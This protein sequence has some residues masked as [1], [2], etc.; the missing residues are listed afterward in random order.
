MTEDS[1]H[2]I[3]P[4]IERTS[5]GVD[6]K[7]REE[8]S[9]ASSDRRSATRTRLNLEVDYNDQ[10]PGE[11]YDPFARLARNLGCNDQVSGNPDDPFKA[12]ECESPTPY[13]SPRQYSPRLMR[14]WFK[15]E[16][17]PNSPVYDPYRNVVDYSPES[18]D[19]PEHPIEFPEVPI[20]H[21][22]PTTFHFRGVARKN[23]NTTDA[24][25]STKPQFYVR[26]CHK[27][28]GTCNWVGFSPSSGSLSSGSLSSDTGT[29]T[30]ISSNPHPSS[31]VKPL[32]T[33]ERLQVTEFLKD[34]SFY[35]DYKSDKELRELHDLVKLVN[36]FGDTSTS[37]TLRN[38]YAERAI[39]NIH[40]D[41]LVLYRAPRLGRILHFLAIQCCE[42]TIDKTDLLCHFKELW[43]TID[44]EASKS[45]SLTDIV[46]AVN[47]VTPSNLTKAEKNKAKRLRKKANKKRDRILI[48]ELKEKGFD[49][50]GF[51][52]LSLEEKNSIEVAFRPSSED[53]NYAKLL[54]RQ[55]HNEA[56]YCDED[57]DDSPISLMSAGEDIPGDFHLFADTHPRRSKSHK[58]RFHLQFIPAPWNL[59]RQGRIFAVNNVSKSREYRSFQ[60][61]IDSGASKHVTGNALLA[62]N[63]NLRDTTV[64]SAANGDLMPASKEGD[65]H[66]LTLE[67]EPIVIQQVHFVPALGANTLL[68]VTQLVEKDNAIVHFC[69]TGSYILFKSSGIQVPLTR[70]ENQLF[71][72]IQIA[73][74]NGKKPI[75]QMNENLSP[76]KFAVGDDVKVVASYF[77][78]VGKP[79]L[80][81]YF[82]GYVKSLGPP[83][84]DGSNT[85]FIYF[86][87]DRK[88][89]KMREI[90]LEPST[91]QLTKETKV[92][93]KGK[94]VVSMN[95]SNNIRRSK[96][97][98]ENDKI[99]S[100][101][102]PSESK[103]T[104]SLQ[105]PPP[106]L[107]QPLPSSSSTPS[108]LSSSSSSF[109]TP[110]KTSQT[111]KPD[112]NLTHEISPDF[113]CRPDER[114]RNFKS[115]GF[116]LSDKF[117]LKHLALSHLNSAAMLKLYPDLKIPN[118]W[119][120][121][122]CLESNFQT[123]KHSSVQVIASSPHDVW[124]VDSF[125]PIH[126]PSNSGYVGATIIKDQYSKSGY[127]HFRKSAP[128]SSNTIEALEAVATQTG[129]FP[130]QLHS[131]MGTE[132]VSEEV[133]MF[134]KKRLIKHTT[135]VAF[136]HSGNGGVETLIK[137]L[138]CHAK[139]NLLHSN[140]PAVFWVYALQYSL[141]CYNISPSYLAGWRSPHEILTGRPPI[142]DTSHPNAIPLHPFGCVVYYKRHDHK[143][144]LAPN[145]TKGFYLGAS[146]DRGNSLIVG[147]LYHDGR[148]GFNVRHTIDVVVR[149]DENYFLEENRLKTPTQLGEKETI[150]IDE[151]TSEDALAIKE[152][153]ITPSNYI[154]YVDEMGDALVKSVEKFSSFIHYGYNDPIPFLGSVGTSSLP[155]P[156]SYKEALNR[157]EAEY[158]KEAIRKEWEENIL[159]KATTPVSI[160]SVA[161]KML[162]PTTL[163]LKTKPG[164]IYKARVCVLGNLQKIIRQRLDRAKKFS[165]EKTFSSSRSNSE[166]HGNTSST[167]SSS[168]TNIMKDSNDHGSLTN[169]MTFAPTV[170][171][172]SVRTLIALIGSKC[173][174]EDSVVRTGDV[175]AAFCIPKMPPDVE[176]YIQAPIKELRKE[177]VVW[178]LTSP[179]YGLEEAPFLWHKFFLK[180]L[181]EINW[182]QSETDQCM[183]YKKNKDGELLGILAIFVDDSLFY[184]EEKLWSEVVNTLSKKFDFKDM[185]RPERFL[186][187]DFTYT[188]G[189]LYV[190][191]KSY[192]EK[193]L[194]KFG[195]GG[196][197]PC[198]TPCFERD[199]PKL[200]VHTADPTL[201]QSMVGTILHNANIC[202]P[203]ISFATSEIAVH[204]LAHNE[205]HFKAVHKVFK[206]LKFMK[207][208]GLYVKE[209]QTLSLEVYCD[210]DWASN[211]SS[212]RSTSGVCILLNGVCVAYYSKKQ[213]SVALSSCEAELFALSQAIRLLGYVRSI[214]EE[215]GVM[216]EKSSVVIYCDSQSAIALAS[217]QAS[218]CP[219]KHIDIRLKHIKEKV[220]SG[221]V[222][223]VYIPSAH[224]VADIFTKGLPVDAHHRHMDVLMKDVPE[225]EEVNIIQLMNEFRLNDYMD[226]FDSDSE[227]G[228]VLESNHKTR[229]T[230]TFIDDT[231]V[232]TSRL[233]NRNELNI[234]RELSED[235]L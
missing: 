81:N 98:V 10:V 232:E 199:L 169:P 27:N 61:M 57:C 15:G 218:Q 28:D 196:V 8:F 5:R 233:S 66:A 95:K 130:R 177:G 99:K 50:K 165:K 186:G 144:K 216:D 77:K 16:Y 21:P 110:P 162:L 191:H 120:C 161:G 153:Q 148:A 183:F 112:S 116:P 52:N 42:T 70:V 86:H 147:D 54:E 124:L 67:N 104:V 36:A 146:T 19:D 170:S 82:H 206:Y 135:S 91:T 34:L 134:L 14:E 208:K 205:E 53:E 68:S 97:E 235:S 100:N 72:S 37:V 142:L 212:R 26:R 1:L 159:K 215:F 136:H 200:D 103:H 167:G 43:E 46:F 187:M 207:N 29:N 33:P 226:S 203:T 64:F 20:L 60:V 87:Y 225:K 231:T 152:Q 189:G 79:P 65:L 93:M 45:K 157:P 25:S 4:D 133:Q 3:T 38:Q 111:N 126:P 164:P 114:V 228:G 185:G 179:L 143:G 90:D 198:K 85:Y 149:R 227:N 94:S 119:S 9:V 30:S 129:Q 234:S 138:W 174:P 182:I 223:L 155:D 222:K 74:D 173:L 55:L 31:P 210:A 190:S 128:S 171:A 59:P 125:G 150:H 105:I 78:L 160:K 6:P 24:P 139:G 204:M 140:A 214:L 184:G 84:K 39:E 121:E 197:N 17:N 122:T 131:D 188:E 230:I 106:T 63:F 166:N 69:S 75:H 180:L 58:H 18:K 194:D 13:F 76:H 132:F 35:S 88:T 56:K 154:S 178:K 195:F 83:H 192:I 172:V 71:L 96:K 11:P 202:N 48:E 89:L 213:K 220:A 158:W 217:S 41:S 44:L 151:T 32:T 62:K 2:L 92:L 49:I 141:L 209:G 73:V 127:I 80:D 115:T 107:P 102:L 175:S 137:T 193:S 113:T 12:D 176:I 40:F 109:F 101:T 47:E 219:Q 22:A 108:S 145:S 181:L 156:I 51:T 224:N 168:Y 117:T 221:Q 23:V 201:Y 123:T 7:S 229:D 118:N 211:K 163:V